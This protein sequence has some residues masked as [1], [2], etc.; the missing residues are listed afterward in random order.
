MKARRRHSFPFLA[1]ISKSRCYQTE[2]E[3]CATRC[4]VDRHPLKPWAKQMQLVGAGTVYFLPFLTGF[5]R[6]LSRLACSFASSA[7][8]F[9]CFLSSRSSRSACVEVSTYMFIAYCVIIRGLDIPPFSL[10][11]L[12]ALVGFLPDV[13]CRF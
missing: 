8:A 1:A 9:S 10:P 7:R 13:P 3:Y 4:F 5:P 11:H 2:I 6:A 12:L